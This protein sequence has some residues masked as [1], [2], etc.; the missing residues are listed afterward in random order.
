M[1]AYLAS[2]RRNTNSLF[3]NTGHHLSAEVH[4]AAHHAKLLHRVAGRG[5]LDGVVGGAAGE[6]HLHGGRPLD[7]RQRHLQDVAHLGRALL[8][9]LHLAPL[10][11]RT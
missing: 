3:H 7:L 5:R 11:Y 10:R 6:R 8:H 9:L 2:D 4:P 1:L